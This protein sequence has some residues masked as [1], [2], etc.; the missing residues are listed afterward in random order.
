MT[1]KFSIAYSFLEEMELLSLE[2]TVKSKPEKE[3]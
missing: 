2:K 3:F 1:N